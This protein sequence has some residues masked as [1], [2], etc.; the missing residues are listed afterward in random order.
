MPKKKPLKLKLALALFG[1]LM[2]LLLAELLLVISKQ[3]TFY[4]SRSSPSQF[5][6]RVTPQGELFYTNLA[7]ASIDFVYDGNTR[8]YF[9]A[10]NTV[11]HTTNTLGFRGS[12]FL[13]DKPEGTDRI[14]A[15]G[16][17]FTFG[18]GV[19]DGDTYAQQLEKRLNSASE[20]HRYE[21]YNFGVGGYN[22]TQSLQL[23]KDLAIQVKPDHVIFGYTLNDAEPALFR[24]D[25]AT[26]EIRRQ[27]RTIEAVDSATHSKPSDSP[28]DKLRIV[29]LIR[30]FSDRRKADELTTDYY[31]SLY[32]S[33]NPNWIETQNKL[34]EFGQFCAEQGVDSTVVIF[35]V[36]YEL[37]EDYP[38]RD[39]HQQIARTLEENSIN[40]ID[41]YPHLKSY[42]A[43]DLWVH[44][45]D[46]HPNE[47]VHAILAE[48]L[49]EQILNAA[50]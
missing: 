11:S 32:E 14:A 3:P 50:D 44:P 19:Y 27:E 45:T 30:K 40:Y 37:T 1:G 39:I 9:N 2:G 6:F 4:K 46:Q 12:T 5:Q 22:T 34:K 13:I 29:Q 25:K 31:H 21:A 41:L 23:L 16:D 15:L 35:P 10:D 48:I 49:V 8:G 20:T 28:L 36:L 42:N 33:E 17:S 38:F 43:T 7:S 26:G 18:E 47:I 24:L